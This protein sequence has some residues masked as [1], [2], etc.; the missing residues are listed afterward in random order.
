MFKVTTHYN[1]HQNHD[2]GG[3]HVDAPD[4]YVTIWWLA[5]AQVSRGG[6][7]GWL[8][9]NAVADVKLYM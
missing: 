8:V 4:G 7:C 9:S 6:A 5:H 2:V 3:C 1:T